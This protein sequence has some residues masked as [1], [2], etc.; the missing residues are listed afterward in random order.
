MPHLFNISNTMSRREE[1]YHRKLLEK[2][3]P[4]KNNTKR[5]NSGES[6]ASIHDLVLSKEE[7][8]E[9]FLNYD[10]YERKSLIDHFLD[11]NT[12]LEK[13]Q[14]VDYEEIGDFYCAPFQ[15][16]NKHQESEFIL[17]ELKRVGNVIHK[18][19][20]KP[21]QIKKII[22]I[23]LL[24][25]IITISYKLANM[26][27]EPIPIWFGIEFNFGLL[28]GYADDRYYF[29]NDYEINP[30]HL[31][32]IGEIEAVQHIGLADD[33]NNLKIELK[34]SK[35]ATLWRFP[36]ETISQSE[37]G[38]E[39]VYQ[40]SVLLFSYKTELNKSWRVKIYKKIS[41]MR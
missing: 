40:S 41:A 34:S 9:R 36:I 38:F 5:E 4:K 12:T 14:T 20:K 35:P 10:F 37:G 27:V 15:L 1:G 24:T 22:E 23:N 30:A 29:S 18:G 16:I 26:Y 28:A 11:P 25:S 13:F 3:N 7:G 33:Y 32:S 19:T 8:L 31:A 39:R 6:V 2:A 17:L 21:V